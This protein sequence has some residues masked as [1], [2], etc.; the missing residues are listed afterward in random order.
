MTKTAEKQSDNDF[1]T[2]G[3]FL[4][5]PAETIDLAAFVG[6]LQARRIRLRIAGAANASS[7]PA[8][9]GRLRGA[10]GDVLMQTASPQAVAGHP[11]PWN[12]PS[13]FEV[14]FRKQGRM[15]PGTDFPS[16]WVMAAQPRRG[17]LEVSLTLFGIA[18]EWAPAAAEALVE[19]CQRID[20]RAA[21][22]GFVPAVSIIDRRVEASVPPP[23]PATTSLELEFL[24]PL[25]VSSRDAA[26]NAVSAF[27]SLGFRL[28]GLARWHG[29]TLDK[30]DWTSL[31]AL[32]HAAEWN[33][34]DHETIRWSRGSQRQNRWIAMQ[35]V[36]GRLNIRAHGD[37]VT[38][39][40][41]LL[42]LGSLTHVGADV[43]FGC[44]RY[45]AQT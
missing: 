17:N 32:L 22:R 18:C 42:Q 28:E 33:W 23:I 9:V 5:A 37:V 30:T 27:A 39:I 21:A 4:R 40:A 1:G 3:G 29:F 12:P 15:T 36:V 10:L 25:V 19:A 2:V 34:L 45:V 35:G 20:W 14:L 13:A 7:E 44:G 31:A 26:E 11:C 41:P 24:S 43:A 16:P 6:R 8:L 38:S